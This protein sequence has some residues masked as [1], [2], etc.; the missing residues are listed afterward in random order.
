MCPLKTINHPLNHKEGSLAEVKKLNDL[1]YLLSV[2]YR[3]FY[4][5]DDFFK[6]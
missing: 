1:Q 3:M 4:F 5:S 2:G 6:K